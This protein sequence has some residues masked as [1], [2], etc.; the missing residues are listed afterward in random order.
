MPEDASPKT[1][2]RCSLHKVSAKM[3]KAGHVNERGQP[4]SAP[5]AR[6]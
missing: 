5:R 2:E 3:A 6:V 1:G 4:F